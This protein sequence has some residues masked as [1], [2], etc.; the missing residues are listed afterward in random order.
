MFNEENPVLGDAGGVNITTRFLTGFSS[1]FSGRSKTK[2]QDIIAQK[3]TALLAESL[4]VE[5]QFCSEIDPALLEELSTTKRVRHYPN[6]LTFWAFLTQVIDDDASCAAAVARVQSWA[7]QEN[8]PIPS[9][10]TSGY[11]EARLSVPIDMLRKVNP[12]LCH[13]LD[14]NLPEQGKWRGLRPKAEDGTTALMPDTDSNRAIYPYPS[15]QADG[16]GFPMMRIGGLIDLSHGGLCG[17]SRSNMNVS[18]L[19]H[20][21]TLSESHLEAGDV[22]IADRLYSGYELIADELQ[23]GVHF[24]GR[25]HQARKIDFRKGRK[26]SANERLVVWE[27]P[28]QRPKG[29]R[30]SVEEWAALPEELKVRIIRCQGPDRQGKKKTRYLVTT[31]LDGIKY[32]AEEV[33]S[34]YF[35]R[36]EIEVRFRD[37][38]TTLGMEMLRTKSPEMVH[39]EVLM[40]MI[41]Y[42]LM[43]LLM[44]KAGVAHGINHRRLSFRGVQQV[45]IACRNDFKDMGRRPVLRERQIVN[46]WERIAERY[47]EERP[48]R[49]EPRRVKRRPKCTRWLQKPRQEYFEHFRSETPPLKI[50]DHAA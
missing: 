46:M 9:S 47:I 7:K 42:N 30:C 45:L 24:I 8:L 17:L 3:R 48:G 49:N 4:D 11:C 20:H 50:L 36:W 34:L 16:C 1:L 5:Q 18:E 31:L 41:V 28:S 35:H 26:L 39:K 13:Q 33:G 21:E 44:L 27:K 23:K 14:C 12:A 40:N 22:L 2:T 29:S 10:H 19:R 32:P 15:G 25:T 43:R 38:K 6:R 37:I